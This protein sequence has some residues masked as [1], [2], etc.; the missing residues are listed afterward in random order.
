MNSKTKRE[1]NVSQSRI[2]TFIK[3]DSFGN[4]YSYISGS[5]FWK[6]KPVKPYS[7]ARKTSAKIMSSFSKRGQP[8]FL[9]RLLFS[10]IKW[11]R[12]SLNGCCWYCY[13]PRIP[14]TKMKVVT[15]VVIMIDFNKKFMLTKWS[16]LHVHSSFFT[17]F[18]YPQFLLT[19]GFGYEK[20]QNT[21]R[22]AGVSYLP[23][24]TEVAIFL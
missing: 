4:T 23:E 21:L 11:I 18:D 12:Y 3:G 1:R 9:D 15:S 17:I 2:Q 13:L 19:I 10:V 6:G 5:D 16:R 20:P 24:A 7:P 14:V 8:C 22:R